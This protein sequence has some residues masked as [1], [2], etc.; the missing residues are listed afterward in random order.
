MTLIKNRSLTNS[1]FLTMIY[2]QITLYSIAFCLF[3]ELPKKKRKEK[4]ER[5]NKRKNNKEKI[6]PTR[7]RTEDLSLTSLA[8][9]HRTDA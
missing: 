8:F 3:I 1:A 5:K 7:N 4:K 9:Y 6:A 2:N